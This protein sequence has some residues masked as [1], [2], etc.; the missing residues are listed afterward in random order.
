VT[1]VL[2]GYLAMVWAHSLCGGAVEIL[3]RW[4]YGEGSAAEAIGT[5]FSAACWPLMVRLFP[6]FFP[7]LLVRGLER[8]EFERKEER[9]ENEVRRG[10]VLILIAQKVISLFCFQARTLLN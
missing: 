3:A 5:A 10:K 4:T 7:L 9:E 8:A 6:V 2:Y 1:A